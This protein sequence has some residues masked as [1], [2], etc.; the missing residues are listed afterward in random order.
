MYSASKAAVIQFNRAISF[1]YQTEGIRTYATAPGTIKTNLLAAEDWE[2]F[3]REFWTPME[4][5]VKAVLNLIAGGE[6]QDTTGRKIAEKNAYGLTVEVFGD[7]YYFRDGPAHCTEN[8][9][10][11]M[12]YTGMKYQLARIEKDKRE[13]QK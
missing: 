11:M 7:G 1:A 12:E 5:L 4:T 2:T 8:M 13:K 9:A 6:L 3:P 10:K